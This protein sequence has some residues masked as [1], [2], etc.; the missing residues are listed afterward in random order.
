LFQTQNWT[1]LFGSDGLTTT[2]IDLAIHQAAEAIKAADA[3][4]ITAGAGMGV[5]SGLPDF[6]GQHGFWRAY[7]AIARRR[8]SFE[9]MAN[10]TWF[11]R[12]PAL[13]WAF[14]GHRLNLYRQTTPHNGFSQLLDIGRAK[15][16][17]YFVFTSNVDG[18][19]QKAGYATDRIVECHGSI[20]HFQCTQPCVTEIWDAAPDTVAILEDRFQAAPPLPNCKH[21][22]ELARPNILMFGDWSWLNGRTALQ[23]DRF[24]AW[25]AQLASQDA[26]LAVIELGA[27]TAIPTVRHTSE[28][29]L[30]QLSGALV[31]INPRQDNLPLGEIALA[32]G[33]ADGIQRICAYLVDQRRESRSSRTK[34]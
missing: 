1:I 11:K 6:R 17:G 27:G 9:E 29:A 30:R 13:A 14:Y 4:L 20:H 19:F 23:K 33:A 2:D 34:H 5:D 7:P 12:D 8:L 15:K 3:L 25:L 28:W 21:C 22:S 26:R 31:R 10:P 24:G 32:L 18:Q 16:H